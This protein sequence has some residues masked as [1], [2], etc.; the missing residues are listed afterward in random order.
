MGEAKGAN[1]A[2]QDFEGDYQ[3]SW[4][5]GRSCWKANRLQ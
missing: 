4:A 5:S 1:S 2:A 3:E